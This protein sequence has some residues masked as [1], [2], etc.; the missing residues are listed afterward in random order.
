MVERVT[1]VEGKKVK[2]IVEVFSDEEHMESLKSR[3]ILN[4]LKSRLENIVREV[5]TTKNI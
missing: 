1:F 2:S 4:M 3:A 5:E